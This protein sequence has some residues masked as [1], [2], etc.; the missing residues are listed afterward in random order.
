M[1]IGCQTIENVY[2]A[3]YVMNLDKQ[4]IE[5]KQKCEKARKEFNV[6]YDNSGL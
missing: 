5:L 1:N 4:I 6:R 3:E 2:N